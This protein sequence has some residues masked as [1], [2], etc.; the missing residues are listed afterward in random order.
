MRARFR[1]GRVCVR[2]L[3]EVWLLGLFCGPTCP[4]PAAM[5][6]SSCFLFWS[7]VMMGESS[8]GEHYWGYNALYA[9]L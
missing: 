7:N 3:V 5:L 2:L 9:P 4:G 1:L 8:V 6:L